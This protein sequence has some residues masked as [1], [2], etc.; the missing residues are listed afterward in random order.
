MKKKKIMRGGTK[1]LCLLLSFLLLSS[2]SF[3][4]NSSKKITGK[5]TDK[6]NGEAIV[7]AS[8]AVRGTQNIVT[9]GSN[10]EFSI[11]TQTGETLTISY[12]GY[13]GQNIKIEPSTNN[14]KIQLNEDYGKLSDVVVIGYGKMRKTDL[15]SSQVTVTANDISK[16]INTTLDQALE[17]RAAN[18]QVSSSNAQ[19]G[20]APSVIIRGLNSLNQSNQPLYVID[21]VQIRPSDPQGGAAGTYNAP[22][23][24]ANPLSG[25]NPDDIET[26]N[27]LQGP[28][29]TAIFG[30]AGGN[31]VIMITTKKGRSG[32]TKIALNT[33]WTIQDLPKFAPVMNLPQYAIFRNELQ[34]AG[35]ASSQPEFADPSVLGN[36]TN[37]QT[38]LFRRTL[39][40]KHSLSLSGGNDKTTFYFSGEYFNQEGV[41]QGSGF[42]RG[43]IRINL[44]NNTRKW[45]RIG[46]NL[47]VNL[48]KEK[49]VS[50]NNS[51]I[52]T[53]IDISP[54]IAVKEADGSW[55]GPAAGTAYANNFINPIALAQINTNYNKG[56]GAIGGVY[57]DITLYKG[58]VFHNEFNGTYNYTNNYQFNPTYIFGITVN[59]TATGSQQTSNNWW[60]GQNSRLQYDT[61]IGN[62]TISAMIG[63]ESSAWGWESL[64]AYKTGFVNNTVQT[65][66]AGLADLTQSNTS[67]KGDAS[68]E[69]YFGRVNYIYNNKYI[70]QGTLRRD[71]AS[72]FGSA[73]RWGNFPSI[74][75]AWKISEEKFMKDIPYLTDLKLR[76]EYGLSG[77]SGSTALAQYAVLTS[78]PASSSF[79]TSYLPSGYYNPNIQWEVD[80]TTNFGFDLHM[81]NSRLEVIFDA[82]QKNLSKLLISTTYPGYFGGGTSQGGL[83]WPV[84]NIAEMHNHGFGITINT[85]N[86][87]NKNFTWKSGLSFSL[88]RNKVTKLPFPINVVYTTNTNNSQTQ[89]LTKEGQPAGMIT[90]YVSEG[91]FQNYQ[92]IT[93]HANQTSEINANV[94]VDPNTGTWVGDVK[95]KDI[96]GDGKITVADRIV[97]GNPWP[98]YTYGFNNFFSY[99][100]FDINVFITGSV[101]NDI[102]NVLRMQNELPGSKGAFENYYQ[103]DINFARPTSYNVADALT[104]TLSNPTTI[105]PRVYTSTAN[106]N[107]RLTQLDVE[108]GSYLKVK[109]LS[110]SYNVPANIASKAYLKGLKIGF[111]VQNLLTITKYKGFDPEVGAFNYWNSGNPTVIS[112]IDNGR[113]PSVRMYSFNLLADF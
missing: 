110:I 54:A 27:V 37:W 8:I 98:K 79:G 30:A 53:A 90:G 97:L 46:T 113:Y 108:K 80:K 5:I 2:Q 33:T 106:G 23:S 105:V 6:K 56:L 31:G 95:F 111:N 75:A 48:T 87:A 15:S 41:V 16:T 109:N 61:K 11:I 70:L 99:K 64:Y 28:S 104:A 78:Y 72:V 65:L 73:N 13:V 76:F 39:L 88:D 60:W 18:V 55:G 50:S 103:S 96:N 71:G 85:V 94:K 26:M 92:D 43:S 29:A 35:G 93:S 86:V 82:Y 51:L 22:T 67:A 20:S 68:K 19:P 47:S 81:F 62:H 42:N 4:Q 74:S 34:K 69:S 10:G 100:R 91:L 102:V 7:G 32:E 83:T 9:S 14:L 63:H 17:G 59:K 77:N 38:E 21:G 58:L 89:F 101:G 45:L 112:G 3:S 57:A 36:G 44:D 66:N 25:I 1:L 40:Q 12:I 107:N 49:I 24:Y 84:Q 52:T